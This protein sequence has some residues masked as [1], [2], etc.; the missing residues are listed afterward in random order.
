M[1]IYV[2]GGGGRSVATAA[3][4]VGRAI[5]AE[6]GSDRRPSP[7]SHRRRP[8]TRR[9]PSSSTP[10][11]FISIGASVGATAVRPHHGQRAQARHAWLLR[12]LTLRGYSALLAGVVT[13]YVDVM[14]GALTG[15]T[16]PVFGA[17]WLYAMAVG[18][19]VTGVAAAFGIGRLDCCS[20]CS[21]WSSATPRPQDRSAGRC[22]RGFYSTFTAIVPQGSGVAL[23]RS[24]AYFG[25]NGV[26][27][28]ARDA[29]DAGRRPVG[30]RSAIARHRHSR[31]NYRAIY[32]RFAAWATPSRTTTSAP[33]T[34]RLTRRRRRRRSGSTAAWCGRT[35]STTRRRS[36]ASS[37][38][39]S[40]T[41]TSR[42]PAGASPTAIGPE[43]QQGVGGVRPGRPGGVAGPGADGT[44]AGRATGG[45]RPSNAA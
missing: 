15:H 34:G 35:R 6:G 10:I 16:W 5:A 40:S 28:P 21:W 29:G 39:W 25:G 1:K 45:P 17:L 12:T 24:V 8:P 4:T 27:D 18:G 31:V 3:E 36:A 22:C 13:L 2:A 32:E 7:T 23:L 26:D 38:P 42:S 30:A 37:G 9:A 11:I 14:L 19:A 20:P 33:I 43:L 44:R 41:P